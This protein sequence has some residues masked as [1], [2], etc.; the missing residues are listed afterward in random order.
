MRKKSQ[1]E[2]ELGYQIQ[3]MRA[4]DSQSAARDLAISL[5]EYGRL[6]TAGKLSR[7]EKDT[8]VGEIGS[9]A[10]EIEHDE[11]HLESFKWIYIAGLSKANLPPETAQA[12]Q[13]LCEARFPF[14][15]NYL[16]ISLTEM[17]EKLR[18]YL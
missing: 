8:L 12:V 14:L 16:T 17:R 10:A 1:Y 2:K 15:Y 9:L 6:I 4:I 3:L 11:E 7:A 13:V 18:A 5:L